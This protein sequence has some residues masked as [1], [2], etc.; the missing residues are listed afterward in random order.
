MLELRRISK[1]FAGIPAVEDVSFSALPG[2]VTGYL[3]P[4]GSGKSTTMKMIAGLFEATSGGNFVQ[5]TADS[6]GPDWVQEAPS[7]IQALPG[8]PCVRSLPR[9]KS[10]GGY[11]FRTPP[12]A[13]PNVGCPISREKCG[14]SLLRVKRR[15]RAHPFHILVVIHTHHQPPPHAD[16]R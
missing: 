6:R 12:P 11:D 13:N 14:F 10:K 8:V 5:W 1:L 3:E 9:A 4:N 2:G 16:D 15:R 7:A